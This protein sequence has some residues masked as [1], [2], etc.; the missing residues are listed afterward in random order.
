VFARSAPEVFEFT[1]ARR[2]LERALDIYILNRLESPRG[3][4][5]VVLRNIT[6]TIDCL[7]QELGLKGK[8]TKT[9]CAEELCKG[10]IVLVDPFRIYHALNCPHGQ[11]AGSFDHTTVCHAWQGSTL[12]AHDKILAAIACKQ[13]ATVEKLLSDFSAYVMVTLIRQRLHL[14]TILAIPL[15]Y[16]S[17]SYIQPRRIR[18][19]GL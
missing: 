12:G 19:E 15:G 5:P 16:G 7:T 14:C 17:F 13:H 11:P 8:E 10:L 4:S 1:K 3:T 18:Y 6:A 2:I 9:K